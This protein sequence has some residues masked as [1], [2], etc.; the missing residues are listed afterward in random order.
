MKEWNDY[1]NF[2]YVIFSINNRIGYDP[3]ILNN[4]K[5]EFNIENIDDFSFKKE[6]SEICLT[7]NEVLMRCEK[8][9]KIMKLDTDERDRDS[10][11]LSSSH[12]KCE[13]NEIKSKSKNENYFDLK[14]F[15]AFSEIKNNE[16]N[17]NLINEISPNTGS[18]DNQNND[19]S[20]KTRYLDGESNNIKSNTYDNNKENDANAS[21]KILLFENSKIL[22]EEFEKIIN[23]NNMENTE[24]KLLNNIKLDISPSASNDFFSIRNEYLIK[25]NSSDAFHINTLENYKSME[26]TD[27]IMKD[28]NTQEENLDKKIPDDNTEKNADNNINLVVKE[29]LKLNLKEKD[30][31]YTNLKDNNENNEAKA[32]EREDALSHTI[33]SPD[34]YKL[35]SNFNFIDQEKNLNELKMNLQSNSYSNATNNKL[36]NEKNLNDFNSSEQNQNDLGKINTNNNNKPDIQ[37]SN[38]SR[39]NNELNGFMQRPLKEKKK[40]IYLKEIQNSSDK[41]NKI[42][43]KENDYDNFNSNVLNSNNSNELN[44]FGIDLNEIGDFEK[45]KYSRPQ[46]ITSK[47]RD[48][49]IKYLN[50]KL[51]SYKNQNKVILDENKKLLEIINIF[52]ILQNLENSKKNSTD[53]NSKTSNANSSSNN[54]G[55]SNNSVNNKDNSINNVVASAEE[56]RAQENIIAGSII[57]NNISNKNSGI[58]VLNEDHNNYEND[59]DDLI[60]FERRNFERKDVNKRYIDFTEASKFL[61]IISSNT[62]NSPQQENPAQGSYVKVINQENNLINK[63]NNSHVSNKSENKTSA[64]NKKLYSLIDLDLDKQKDKSKGKDVKASEIKI[65]SDKAIQEYSFKLSSTTKDR[66]ELKLDI[67]NKINHITEF[68][69]DNL[70]INKNSIIIHDSVKPALNI[71]NNDTIDSKKIPDLKNSHLSKNNKDQ[72]T[73]KEKKQ[74]NSSKINNNPSNNIANTKKKFIKIGENNPSKSGYSIKNN[75]KKNNI[76]NN[77]TISY[78]KSQHETIQKSKN[79]I[80]TFIKTNNYNKNF[81]NMHNTINNSNNNKSD[82]NLERPVNNDSF[83]TINLNYN[84]ISNSIL[85]DKHKTI[86]ENL[87]LQEKLPNDQNNI[88]VAYNTFNINNTNININARDFYFNNNNNNTISASS[89]YQNHNINKYPARINNVDIINTEKLLKHNINLPLKK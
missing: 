10:S 60:H 67:I 54:N 40:N 77:N 22:N 68:N 57:N 13:E 32:N 25:K 86:E 47:S 85:S 26:I 18:S 46:S 39:I 8:E 80:T 42:D 15:S 23:E 75:L 65:V 82:L 69:V 44:N 51:N 50:D 38:S 81:S 9:G 14:Y 36:N 73:S 48:D 61:S 83:N 71:S 70:N 11:I 45:Y 6:E 19:T 78:D 37:E 58:N 34:N 17:H 55:H 7:E 88:N 72:D 41:I 66:H 5:V 76:I 43:S 87:P 53:P 52:K 89:N 27:D 84:N 28:L 3:Y 12:K 2:E 30:N 4:S 49:E 33:G 29:N 56:K 62:L 16:L 59:R 1:H 31:N 74:T 24:D 21:E 79:K 20:S 64:S 35:L 63:I